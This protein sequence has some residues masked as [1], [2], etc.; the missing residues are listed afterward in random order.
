MG[1]ELTRAALGRSFGPKCEE[2]AKIVENGP[3]E[4]HVRTSFKDPGHLAWSDVESGVGIDR[5]HLNGRLLPECE[6]SPFGQEPST[7]KQ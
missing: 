5:G 4:C 3:P 6:I 7:K 2:K 1:V